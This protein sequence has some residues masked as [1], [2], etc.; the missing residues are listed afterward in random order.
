MNGY[1]PW[2]LLNRIKEAGGTDFVKIPDQLIVLDNTIK[3]LEQE[4]ADELAKPEPDIAMVRIIN[5]K[6][7]ERMRDIEKLEKQIWPE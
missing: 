3:N 1:A 7:I 5:A 4:L 6:K 2:R